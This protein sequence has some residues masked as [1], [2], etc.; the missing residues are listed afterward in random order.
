MLFLYMRDTFTLSQASV[1]G[2][3]E[4]PFHKL[5]TRLYEVYPRTAS[6]LRMLSPPRPSRRESCIHEDMQAAVELQTKVVG[7]SNV[8]FFNTVRCPMMSVGEADLCASRTVA[9]TRFGQNE[10]PKNLGQGNSDKLQNTYRLKIKFDLSWNYRR[11]RTMNGHEWTL[12]AL[13]KAKWRAS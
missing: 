4:D 9:T 7:R 5:S 3:F 8:W 13:S 11:N 10:A 12:N 2:N 1:R 6:P